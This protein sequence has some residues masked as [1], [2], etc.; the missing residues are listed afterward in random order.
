MASKFTITYTYF[1][2]DCESVEVV[3]ET[4]EEAEAIADL[5]REG[6]CNYW[7]HASLISEDW[8]LDSEEEL[9]DAE[10]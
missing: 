6:P 10:V 7:N 1:Y 2:E 8:Q 3:A 9:E 5:E 4:L